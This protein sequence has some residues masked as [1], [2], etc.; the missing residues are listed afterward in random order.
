MADLQKRVF[1]EEFNALGALDGLKSG[2][3]EFLPTA[4]SALSQSL[5]CR[6]AGIGALSA[7]KTHVEIQRLHDRQG[8]IQPFAYPLANGPCEKVYFSSPLDPFWSFPRD[9]SDRFAAPDFLRYLGIESYLAKAVYDA[10]GDVFAHV[11]VLDQAPIIVSTEVERTFRMLAQRIGAVLLQ[12][13]TEEAL[14]RSEMRYRTVI[15]EIADAVFIH[16]LDG[17]F[18][19]VN[20]QACDALGYSRDELL[21]MNVA[22]VEASM[23]AEIVLEN[24]RNSCL[25]QLIVQEGVHVRKDGTRFPAELRGRIVQVDGEPVVI[26]CA[27]DVSVLKGAEHSLLEARRQAEAASRA[28]SDFVA[29]MSHE[30][31]TPLNAIIGFSDILKQQHLGPIGHSRYAEY[32]DDIHRSGQH[33]LR[34]VSDILDLSKIEAGQETLNET[35]FRLSEILSDS[36]AILSDRARRKA[37]TVHLM[38]GPDDI[39]LRADAVKLEQV[40]INL[41]TNAV[42]FSFNGS[43]VHVTTQ[44]TEDGRLEIAVSDSGPGIEPDRL[45]QAFESFRR[46]DAATRMAVE[47]TGLGLPI[48]RKLCELHGGTIHLESVVG[49]GTSAIV[50][51]PS[52]RIVAAPDPG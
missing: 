38:D 52:E 14:R 5:G 1:L 41:L 16:D 46:L 37:V 4:L 34:L 50:R 6:L 10:D 45:E 29:N 44:F 25:G 3:P 15:D 23:P 9:V 31:R 36:I 12:R 8:T 28:K 2:D 22:D 48:A 17:Q 20:Q 21:L 43:K 47:G 11:F 24:W 26:V 30:L 49:T 39:W 19:D 7:D 42:K 33:L 13:R 40:L 51:M 32:A 18:V 35:E 27:R